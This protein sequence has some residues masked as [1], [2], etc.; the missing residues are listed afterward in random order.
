METV[1]AIA[2]SHA[3]L[4]ATR[5]D[6]AESG[7]SDRWFKAAGEVRQEIQELSPDAIVLIGTD[8]MKA[9]TLAGGVP[10][11]AIGV[12]PVAHGLGD[13]GV[14]SRDVPIHQELAA[15]LLQRFV[16][17]GG[18]LT[19]RER[20]EIDHSFVLPLDLL[21]PAADF[22]IV[23]ITQNCN[24]PPR[25]TMAAS[26]DFGARLRAA[27]SDLPGRV[28]V[29]ATGG[30]S[31]WVGDDARRAFMDRLP[32]TR[33]S[34]LEQFPVELEETG[35]VNED[36]D[37]AFLDAVCAGRLLPFFDDWP[38]ERLQNEAGNG[39]H[40]LRNWATL[41]GFLDDAAGDVVAYEPVEE[42][43]TGVGIVRFG[44]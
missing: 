3:G 21:D 25:P 43:L 12:G 32:G 8:H 24:V 2:C 22:P 16:A 1:L 19:F 30:L 7:Q 20:A 26:H 11:H 9:W 17:G 23:P 35:P 5:K 34:D 37:R 39:A 42:W 29:I 4:I 38:D 44:R 15:G 14:P 27:A 36:F 13:A 6:R 41:C 28:V 40:E 10:P 31:H 33:V 18:L